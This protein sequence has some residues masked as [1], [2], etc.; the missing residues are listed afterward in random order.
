MRAHY[1]QRMVFGAG[2]R[3]GRRYPRRGRSRGAPP[4]GNPYGD[5]Y[6]DP[7]GARYGAPYGGYRRRG[8]GN[9][10]RD[11]CLLEGGCCVGEALDGNCLVLTA[12]LAPALL[13]AFA[14]GS[15]GTF[16]RGVA[17]VRLSN[18]LMAAIGL[19]QERISPRLAGRCRFTPS[20]SQYAAEALQAHGCVRGGLLAGRRLLR[21]RPHGPRGADPVPARL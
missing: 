14:T 5:P 15:G 1:G 16:A 12:M 18:R 13:R 8:G 7:Y 20:C 3:G 4:Y 11:A 19:Y 21:C 6:G 2:W 9:C 10:L 17:P